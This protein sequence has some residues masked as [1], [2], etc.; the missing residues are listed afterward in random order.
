MLDATQVIQ[1]ET[2]WYLT[3]EVNVDNT[4]SGVTPFVSGR[5]GVAVSVNAETSQPTVAVLM[6]SSE[7]PLTKNASYLGRN[8]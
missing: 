8:Q 2:L 4:M 1:L 6:G 3:S 5:A 7:D